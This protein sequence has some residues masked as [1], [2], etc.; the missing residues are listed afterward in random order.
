MT[1]F[2]SGAKYSAFAAVS[3]V[4]YECLNW[5]KNGVWETTSI[6][7]GLQINELHSS[8]KGADLLV[9]SILNL[10]MF[11]FWLTL[12]GL[13]ALLHSFFSERKITP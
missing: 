6:S 5:M 7:E 11:F 1:F 8:W 12:S 2:Y 13:M 4:A 3:I 9:N 10:D